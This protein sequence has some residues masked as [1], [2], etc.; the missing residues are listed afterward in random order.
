MTAKL[1]VMTDPQQFSFK[2]ALARSAV[3]WTLA[4]TRLADPSGRE[5]DLS[6]VESARL[7]DMPAGRFWTT[8]LL[9]VGESGKWR[10]QCNATARSAERL[11][12]LEAVAATLDALGRVRPEL[13]VKIGPGRWFNWVVALMGLGALLFG[14]YY[15]VLAAIEREL[16]LVVL[17]AFFVLPGLLAIWGGSPWQAPP[18]PAPAEAART[19]RNKMQ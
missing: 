12:C 10:M 11:R 1:A 9:L 13:P 14:L 16:F 2:P 8:E 19:A 4:G 6:S 5:L 3:T 17:A 15:L 7:T 18:R